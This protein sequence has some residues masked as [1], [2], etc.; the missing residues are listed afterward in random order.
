MNHSHKKLKPT[1]ILY[2]IDSLVRGGTELQLIGLIER[3][4]PEEFQPYLLTIRSTDVTLT[5]RNCVHLAW[6]V[7]KLFSWSG[8][9]AI[10]QLVRWLKREKID[11][12]QTFFQDSTIFGGIAARLAGTTVRIA[13][14]RDLGFW[15]NR[16][17]R[18]LMRS[19]Y[20]MMNAYICNADI[21]RDHFVTYFAISPKKT[22]VLRNGIDVTSLTFVERPGP[23]RNI[24]IVG[25]MTRHVKRTDLFIKA[26]GIVA[27]DHPDITWHI[28]GDGHMRTELEQQAKDCNVFEK[29][30]FA[31]RVTNV[32]EYLDILDIGVICS[33]SEGLS[34][35]LLEYL[36]KGTVA[37]AT[38]V[39]GNLELIDDD[40][41]GLLVPPNDASA[42]ARAFNTLIKDNHLRQLLAQRARA[43]A[44]MEYNW[45]KCL[46]GHRQ[47][48]ND[49]LRHNERV[50]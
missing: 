36:F 13:C 32:A 16:K 38:A 30:V 22:K 31:G 43:K 14:C 25:N 27:A 40:V 15:S 34:N 10:V 21:V 23:T 8:I 17:Q 9:K 45:E 41:T 19:V 44:E 26:A 11:I 48:Y 20:P 2:C 4:N 35:A 1:K 18:L 33:D 29:I 3:L 28:I 37:V 47:F 46:S 42:L 49:L 7:P 6:D 12:V 5:P 50:Q 39:G 24:G